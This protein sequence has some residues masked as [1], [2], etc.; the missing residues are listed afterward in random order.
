V[1]T[2]RR[3]FIGG[4]LA[5]P[6]CAA[7]GAAPEWNYGTAGPDKWAK[8]DP[9]FGVCGS[10]DQQ[11]PIDLR[12]GIK[13][14]IPKL[15]ITWKKDRFTVVNNGHT[16]QLSAANGSAMQV[17]HEK[18]DL[19]QFHFHTPSEH[20]IAGKRSAMEVHF[21]HQHKDGHL[22]VLAALLTV[23]GRNG[24]FSAIM[25]AAPKQKDAK[26]TLEASIDPAELIPASIQSTW[27]YEG[28]LTTPPC[29]QTVDWIIFDQ[30]ISVAQADIDAFRAIF[31]NNARPL[32]PNAR[33][34]LLRS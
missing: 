13:A 9:A 27:R 3:K 7:A 34:Y 5:C 26:A 15:E 33:R 16:V 10:G 22:A 11:S 4:L 19:V 31:P 18:L 32:Q 17:G 23:G 25:K 20:A 24:A 12:D 6:V 14:D 29:S 30:T 28:S 1:N 2:S 21:V 8:L